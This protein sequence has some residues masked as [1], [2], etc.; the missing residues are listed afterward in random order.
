M[1]PAAPLLSDVQQRV[2]MALI[3]LLLRGSSLPRGVVRS[4]F[5][6]VAA[7]ASH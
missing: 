3:W 2:N 1:T 4:D 6:S 5:V 7:V